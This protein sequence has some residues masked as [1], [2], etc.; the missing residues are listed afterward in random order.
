MELQRKEYHG[1]TEFLKE[2]ITQG[3]VVLR[4]HEIHTSDEGQYV[5]MF[6]TFTFYN[7]VH[8]PLQVTGI[9]STPHIHLEGGESHGI[10][11][12]CTSSGWY[13]EPSVE[14]TDSRGQDLLPLSVTE[15]RMGNVLFY[16]ETTVIL[17]TQS[18]GNMS[19]FIH[20]TLLDLKKEARISVAGLKIAQSFADY[21]EE[22]R[23]IVGIFLDYEAGQVSFYNVSNLSHIYT[24][25]KSFRG[26]LRSFFYPGPPWG[27][28]QT[29]SDHPAVKSDSAKHRQKVLCV[30]RKLPILDLLTFGIHV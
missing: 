1:R 10:Q 20:N 30:I 25:R 22:F 8:F 15:H 18:Q 21:F 5:C 12:L 27:T 24:Y 3:I 16:V 23:E 19:C 17:L 9:S 4:L 11:L 7:E 26:A 29:T 14:W 13:P 6:Q 28:K 2:N